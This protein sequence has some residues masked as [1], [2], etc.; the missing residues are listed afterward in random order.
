ME[1][2]GRIYGWPLETKT[3]M[4]RILCKFGHTL[5]SVMDDNPHMGTI[6][7]EH[8]ASRMSEGQGIY[9]IEN[10]HV[11]ECYNCG[12]IALFLP[13]SR[14]AHWLKREDEFP[15]TL[16]DKVKYKLFED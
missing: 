11:W 9:D 6:I 16:L 1:A 4:S 3:A 13:N 8:A 14:D 5:S 10:I 12:R 2:K 7:T 15:L